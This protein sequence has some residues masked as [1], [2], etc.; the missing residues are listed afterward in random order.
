VTAQTTATGSTSAST[1]C[2]PSSP[3]PIVVYQPL[4]QTDSVQVLAEVEADGSVL[5]LSGARPDLIDTGRKVFSPRAG[6]F[7]AL[8]EDQE[9]W[10]QSFADTSKALR[11]A[12]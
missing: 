11:S 6:G 9:E 1:R 7:I 2:T 3:T 8:G 12:R 10:L 5:K 4:E